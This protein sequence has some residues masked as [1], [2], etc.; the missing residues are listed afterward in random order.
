MGRKGG[1]IMEKEFEAL[2]FIFGEALF[3]EYKNET[4]TRVRECNDVVF[5]A[6]TELKQINE[7]KPSEALECLEKLK[8]YAKSDL[9]SIP[10]YFYDLCVKKNKEIDNIVENIKQALLKAQEQEKVLEIIKEKN[11]DI[12]YLRDCETVGEYNKYC[13]D[14]T[15]EKP[16]TEKEFDTVKMWQEHQ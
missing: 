11:V 14:L 10:Q 15:D 7:A 6:L 16:L 9:D 13:D 4:H 1:R 5:K 12:K 8:N 3:S 2:K